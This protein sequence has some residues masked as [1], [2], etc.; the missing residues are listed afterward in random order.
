MLHLRYF[1][2]VAEQL[3]FSAAARQLHMATSPL[4]RRVRDLER[5][6]GSVLFDRDSH[7]VQLTDS[8]RA[9]LPLARDVLTRFD[10]IPWRMRES[11]EPQPT[12]VYIGV[13][14]GLHRAVRDR[15]REL[16]ERCGLS[17]DIKR[18]PGG[19]GDL[20]AA[21][22]RGELALALVHLPVHAEGVEVR[23]VFREPLGAVLPAREFGSHEHVSLSELVELTYVSPASRMLPARFDE[24][25]ARLEAAGVHRRITVDTGDYGSTS[26]MVANGSAFSVSMLDPGSAMHNHRA[27]GTVVLPFA[28]FDPSLATGMIWRHD[29][30]ASQPDLSRLLTRAEA[31]LGG[32]A[33]SV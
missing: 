11:G 32:T 23:E 14:P 21:V 19:S 1:V 13:P 30:A 26:E 16:D 25:R 7:H 20:L 2:A 6:L 33:Q 3:S 17:C 12:A 15:L 31:V 9:L 18:W 27:D 24:I 8:G 29:R 28:D 10:D 22:Q 5:E 4:S